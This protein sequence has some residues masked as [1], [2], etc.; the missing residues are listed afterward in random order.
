[1]IPI[2]TF[3]VFFRKINTT[4][5]LISPDGAQCFE[6]NGLTIFTSSCILLFT[7]LL[8]FLIFSDINSNLSLNIRQKQ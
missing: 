7:K 4:D 5:D 8:A 1:M 3:G 6:I 2:N